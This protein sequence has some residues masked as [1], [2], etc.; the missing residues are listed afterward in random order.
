MSAGSRPRQRGL[1]LRSFAAHPREVGAILPT[2]RR[3]VRDTLDLANFDAARCVVELG[4]GTGVYTTATLERLR[5]D[6]RL[7]AFEI[8]ESMAA[9]LAARIDDPR[10][11]VVNDS[12]EKVGAY[13]DGDRADII[14]S[15]LPFTSLP[16]GV[17]R[18][19]LAEARRALAPGGVMLV[20][21]YSPFIQ[22]QLERTF[23][24]V[25]RRLSVLN[26]P[27][28]FLFACEVEPDEARA[29]A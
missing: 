2:S 19:V 24:S 7:I 18:S 15:A 6:A 22:S 11:Q 4:A 13:L 3:T 10:L 29:G 20:L 28:A 21:Q 26:L 27:P 17:R 8:D 1:F 16:A 5:P 25:R 23:P 12:A 14:I 9:D